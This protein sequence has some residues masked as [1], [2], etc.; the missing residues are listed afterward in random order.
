MKQKVNFDNLTNKQR[1]SILASVRVATMKWLHAIYSEIM[2]EHLF[3]AVCECPEDEL[4]YHEQ[5]CKEWLENEGYEYVPNYSPE[6]FCVVLKKKGKVVDKL[7]FELPPE[8]YTEGGGNIDKDKKKMEV[9][10]NLTK[11]IVDEGSEAKAMKKLGLDP[12]KN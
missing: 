8:L 2:P 10:Q 5:R 9:A 11:L 1:M 7:E 6:D 3:K 12:E 4:P